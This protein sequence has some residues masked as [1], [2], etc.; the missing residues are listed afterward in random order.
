MNKPSTSEALDKLGIHFSSVGAKSGPK[1]RQA[2]NA[3]QAAAAYAAIRQGVGNRAQR[4]VHLRRG[5]GIPVV[6][7]RPLG[8]R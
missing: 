7:H 2:Y 1:N 6:L 4:R 3:G 5:L 8:A